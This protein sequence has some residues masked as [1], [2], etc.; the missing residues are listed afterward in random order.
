MIDKALRG[1]RSYWGWLALLGVV[2]GIGVVNYLHQLDVGLTVTGMSRDVSW[3]LYISQFTFLV[4]VAASAVMLV[5]PYYLH[6]YEKF[7]KIVVLGES[8]AVAAV[9]MCLMFVLAD[10][11]QVGRALNLLLHPT[12]S[13]MLFWDALVLQG[14]L[15]L[16]VVIGWSTQFA[17]R[18]HLP[19]PRWVKVL[20]YVS[21]PWAF[22]IH[23]VT[24][25]LYAGLPGRHLWLTAILA[26]RFLASAF[27]SG[28][29]LLILLVFLHRRLTR[30]DPGKEPINL[31]ASI[32]TYAMIANLFFLGLEFF[33]A[34]YS[35][36][37]SHQHTLQYLFVGLEGHRQLVPFMWTSVGLGVAGVVLL[38]VPRWRQNENLLL[39]GCAAIFIS[40]F[41]DKG[42]GLVIGGFV[43]SPLNHITEYHPGATELAISAGIWAVGALVLTVLFKIAS[44]V[45]DEAEAFGG[46]AE[47]PEH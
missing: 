20:I 2:I 25:F 45:R 10:I 8:V 7:G 19:P 47:A 39:A 16:N 38:L 18:H 36:I 30:F 6:N 14:Y 33:T 27:A 41:I 1:P 12:P 11:G 26:P 42:M 4:G 29:A 9:T 21:I 15:V 44:G 3:G 28:P 5:L 43:P 24:A 46:G 37:P 35:N 40:A 31:L 13:S 34:F 17:E 32:V 22:S 23:T